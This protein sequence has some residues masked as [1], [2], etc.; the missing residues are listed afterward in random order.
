VYAKIQ[1]INTNINRTTDISD[2]HYINFTENSYFCHPYLKF[3]QNNGYEAYLLGKDGE[4]KSNIDVI[5]S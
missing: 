4:P 1:L 5:I 3:T 2:I